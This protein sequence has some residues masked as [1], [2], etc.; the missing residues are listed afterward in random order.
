[1]EVYD[2]IWAALMEMRKPGCDR[3]AVHKNLS[4]EARWMLGREVHTADKT[5]EPRL[6]PL[7]ELQAALTKGAV[8]AQL[9]ESRHVTG[10][11]G[12]TRRRR[13]TRRRAGQRQ[14]G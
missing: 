7:T 10:R 8:K 1:M 12:R 3:A 6:A 2:E 5:K 4:S 11:P 14:N 13:G 9:T